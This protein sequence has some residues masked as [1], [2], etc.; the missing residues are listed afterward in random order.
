MPGKKE[1][2]TKLP[3]YKCC[4][5]CIYF[6][7]STSIV[8]GSCIVDNMFPV[9]VA[10]WKKHCLFDPSR[11]KEEKIPKYPGGSRG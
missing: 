2:T 11:F 8:Y 6:D 4:W 3:E 10:W 7:I 9:K 1:D 5:N